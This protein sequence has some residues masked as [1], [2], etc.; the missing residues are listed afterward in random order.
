MPHSMWHIHQIKPRQL[1]NQLT[2]FEILKKKD[3]VI[4][5]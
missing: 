2:G 3:L 1:I 4:V 5:Y